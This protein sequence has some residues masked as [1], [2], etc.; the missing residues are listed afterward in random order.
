M[1]KEVPN[2]SKESDS[3]S[4]S[5]EDFEEIDLPKKLISILVRLSF[6]NIIHLL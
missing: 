2:I 5:S 4:G 6:Q 3:N 1:E